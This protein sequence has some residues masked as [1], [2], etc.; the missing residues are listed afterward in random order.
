MLTDMWAVD[1]CLRGE[2][3]GKG[4]LGGWVCSLC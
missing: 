4:L 3:M 1:Q 2:G